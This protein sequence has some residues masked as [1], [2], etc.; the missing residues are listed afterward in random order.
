M[1]LTQA[2]TVP[3][4]LLYVYLAFYFNVLV[5]KLFNLIAKNCWHKFK[6]GF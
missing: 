1:L 5:N 4:A 2:W 6:Y 3:A